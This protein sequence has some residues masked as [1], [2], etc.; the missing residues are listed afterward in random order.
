MAKKLSFIDSIL[1]EES[2]QIKPCTYRAKVLR[3]INIVLKEDYFTRKPLK[4]WNCI[5]GAEAR[6]LALKLMKQ[7]P[8]PEPFE[9][10]EKIARQCSVTG[11][12]MNE[13]WVTDSGNEY[14]K[15]EED[16]LAWCN[17]HGYNSIN[18]A[19][20]NDFIYWTEW[21]DENC[22]D[23][24]YIVKNGE[25]IGIERGSI[26]D[27]EEIMLNQEHCQSITFKSNE[28]KDKT[29]TIHQG[30]DE[31]VVEKSQIKTLCSILMNLEH[32]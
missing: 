17:T 20:E 4:K 30:E 23:Y 25:V 19:Y 24:Q 2:G 3:G 27:Y 6:K 14:F 5:D 1:T 11:E 15:Y 28:L 26:T 31:I 29:I 10:E 13:G 16:A 21:Y 12:G 9:E 32:E 7:A 8:L 18:E 22:D